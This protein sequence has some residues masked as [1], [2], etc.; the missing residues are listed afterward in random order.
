MLD[1]HQHD[2]R[3]TELDPDLLSTPFRVQTNWHVIAGAPCCGKT[4]LIDQLADKGFQTVPESARLY[5]EREMDQ[6]RRVHPI[7]SDAAA[8]QRKIKDM[9][10]SI[11]GGLRANDVLFLDGAVPGSLAFYRVFGL[12]PNEI[13]VE[14][15]HHRYASVFILEPLPFQTDDERVEE[16]ADITGYL[17]EWHTRDYIALGYNVV[18]VPVMPPEE[19][20][21]FVLERLSELGLI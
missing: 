8:L 12:D 3:A 15:F 7:L 11:E 10:Q 19:R 20:L 18:T 4:T 17:D 1:N 2:F 6:G 13:L 16:V 5:I 21:A 9:Q 14:C